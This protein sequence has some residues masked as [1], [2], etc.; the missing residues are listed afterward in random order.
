MGVD[1][2][3]WG[4]LSPSPA[5]SPGPFPDLF[6]PTLW[7]SPGRGTWLWEWEE[8]VR[9]GWTEDPVLVGSGLS[10]PPS[11]P[12]APQPYQQT[13][14]LLGGPWWDWGVCLGQAMEG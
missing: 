5:L 1:G 13:S 10:A 7:D 6:L 11:A 2:A 14:S 3:T 4:P 12:V 9:G 8:V